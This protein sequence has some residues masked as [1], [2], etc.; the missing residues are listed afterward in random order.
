[1]A[2]NGEECPEVLRRFLRRVARDGLL[3]PSRYAGTGLTASEV[4]A[5]AELAGVDGLSQ[6]QLGERLG[7]EKS[8]T[9][10]LAAGLEGRGWLVRE[11]DPANRRYYRLRLTARGRHVARRVVS[12][13]DAHRR[14][15]L[16]AL[17]DDERAALTRGLGALTRVL[18]EAA[19]ERSGT[20]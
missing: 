15:L 10:R 9:S 13:L 4:A 14:S 17:T 20:G 7:L 8:T 6:R 18:D 11:R 16:A 12:D 5:L 1:M 19:G 2:R 3:E